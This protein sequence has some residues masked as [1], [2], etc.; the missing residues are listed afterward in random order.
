MIKTLKRNLKRPVKLITF[1]QMKREK[2]ITINSVMLPSKEV[3]EVVKVS[4]DLIHLLFLIFLRTFLVISVEVDQPE[5]LA[6]EEMI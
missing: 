4:V 1:S 3:E 5:G 2:Q 6:I